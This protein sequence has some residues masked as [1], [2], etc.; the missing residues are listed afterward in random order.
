M[1]SV[2]YL[3]KCRVL[4]CNMIS[5][6]CFI[7][8]TRTATSQRT[9]AKN[10]SSSGVSNSCRYILKQQNQSH[11]LTG[12]RKSIAVTRWWNK[13]NFHFINCLST[14]TESSSKGDVLYQQAMELMKQS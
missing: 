4:S 14:T 7:A 9:L 6:V 2:L 12:I 1:K 11:H 8:G 10:Y 3:K 13:E 5:R